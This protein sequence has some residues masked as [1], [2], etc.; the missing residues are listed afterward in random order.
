MFVLKSDLN[1][2][3]PVNPSQVGLRIRRWL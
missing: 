2:R 1:C 3:S